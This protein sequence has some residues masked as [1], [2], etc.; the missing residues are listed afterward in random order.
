MNILHVTNELNHADG[1]SAHLYN[2]VNELNRSYD[3]TD[4]MRM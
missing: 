1:V 3:E 2:L 4:I